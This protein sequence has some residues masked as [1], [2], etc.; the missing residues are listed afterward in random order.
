VGEPRV[1]VGGAQKHGYEW[2]IE[3]IRHNLNLFDVVR[4]DH[5][6]GLMAYWEVP[7]TETI[8]V[9][10]QWVEAPGMDFFS[11]LSDVFPDLPSLRRI[12]ARSHRMCG[13]PWSISD[14]RA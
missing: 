1:P 7:A 9:N 5:F 4:V 10:G 13:P 14:F 3:R 2:W 11:R 8:A 6:R 12:L